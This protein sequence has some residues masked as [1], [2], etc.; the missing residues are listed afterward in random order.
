MCGEV[1]AA[2]KEQR[3]LSLARM[4]QRNEMGGD[5]QKNTA[6]DSHLKILLVFYREQTVD[7][8]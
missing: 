5:D 8:G 1:C 2:G 4:E 3:K 6:T 7:G